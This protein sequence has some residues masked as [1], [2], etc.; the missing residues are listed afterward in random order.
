[1]GFIKDFLVGEKS[2]VH[3]SSRPTRTPEQMQLLTQLIQ[4]FQ[5]GVSANGGQVPTDLS[6]LERT[7]LAALEELAMKQALGEGD[8]T[9]DAARGAVERGT[10]S[11]SMNLDEFNTFFKGAVEDPMIRSFREEV[12]PEL[13]RRFSGSAAFGSDRRQAEQQAVGRLGDSL[14]SSRA[15]LLF[16]TQEAGRDRALTAAG[17]APDLNRLLDNKMSS[18]ILLSLLSGGSVPRTARQSNLDRA[19]AILGIEP[20]EN[21]TVVKPGTTGFLQELGRGFGQGL[22]KMAGGS[23][24]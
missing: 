22:G 4:M 13:T 12:I 9:M 5:G 24:F 17:I 7:S 15:D 8:P 11:D 18:E 10:Q 19:L 6:S 21:Q 2:S 16:K 20:I 14:A 3:E 1:M 23:F